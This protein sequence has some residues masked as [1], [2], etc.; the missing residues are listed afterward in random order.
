M[1]IDSLHIVSIYL[2]VPIHIALGK[3]RKNIFTANMR[4]NSLHIVG[5]YLSV[6]VHIPEKRSSCPGWCIG[7]WR[8]RQLTLC[9]VVSCA[10]II[11][12]CYGTTANNCSITTVYAPTNTTKE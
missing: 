4:I 1:R 11:C 12:V 8:E 10:F 6:F 2:T 9:I 5:I 7:S 3:V